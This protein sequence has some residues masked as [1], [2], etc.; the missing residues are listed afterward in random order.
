[1]KNQQRKEPFFHIQNGVLINYI[2]NEADVTIPNIVT[3]IG[4]CAFSESSLRNIYVCGN[5]SVDDRCL[6]FCSATVR[7]KNTARG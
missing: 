2:G 7:H 6:G 3:E 4:I 1:M 5:Y